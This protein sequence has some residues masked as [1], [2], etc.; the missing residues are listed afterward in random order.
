MLYILLIH[1]LVNVKQEEISASFPA[2]IH[3]YLINLTKPLD[4]V[5]LQKC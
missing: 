4:V 2:A 1:T 3:G 5:I